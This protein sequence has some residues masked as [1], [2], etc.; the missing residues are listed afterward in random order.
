[1]LFS[2]FLYNYSQTDIVFTLPYFTISALFGFSI[3]H[4]ISATI[5]SLIVFPNLSHI[6]ILLTCFFGGLLYHRYF[7]PLRRNHPG[8]SINLIVTIVLYA[9][10]SYSLDNSIFKSIAFS[11]CLFVYTASMLSSLRQPY[12]LNDIIQKSE[13]DPLTGL[14]NRRY[15][16][17]FAPEIINQTISDNQ[18][19][20][21]IM[22]DID[23]FKAYNDTHGHDQGDSLLIEIADIFKEY[24]RNQDIVIRWGGEEFAIL[25]PNTSLSQAEEIALRLRDKFCSMNY[26]SSLP[27][28]VVYNTVSFGISAMPEP[29]STKEE[30][31]KHADIALYKAKEK[32]NNVVVFQAK[33]MS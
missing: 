13:T 3:H 31:E 10:I 26:V 1:M 33:G 25:L 30:L 19:V 16:N 4:L 11:I 9:L 29:S 24:T 7:I 18:P 32:R 17:E 22:A 20:S 6:M 5:L 12:G 8:I 15:Y 28:Q 21:F 23:H 14:Y 2:L 27:D